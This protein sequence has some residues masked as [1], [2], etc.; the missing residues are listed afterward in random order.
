MRRAVLSRVTAIAITAWLVAIFGTSSAQEWVKLREEGANF[1]DIQR[2]FNQYWE[3]REVQKGKGWKPFKRWEYWTAPRVYPSGI[4]PEPDMNTRAFQQY[5]QRRGALMKGAATPASVATAIPA[6]NWTS[7]GPNSWTRANGSNVAPGLGRVSAIA[8]HPTNSSII[9]LGTPAGGLWK[10]TDAGATWSTN[11]ENLTVLGISAIVI[12]P[13]NTNVMYIATGDYD[14]Q[15]TYSIGVLKSTDGGATWNTTG[16]NWTVT[17]SRTISKLLIHP[18]FPDTLYAATSSGIYRTGNAGTTWSQRISSNWKDIEFKPGVPTTVYGVTNTQFWKTTNRG[19]NW[20]QTTTGVPAGTN[21]F[22]IGVSSNNANYVYLFASRSDNSGFMGMY[23]STDSGVSFATQS[24]TPNILGYDFGVITPP[25]PPPQTGADEGGQGNYDLAFAVSPTDA[26]KIYTGGINIWKSTDGGVNWTR[27]THW[28]YNATFPAADPAYVHADVHHLEFNGSTLFTGTDGGFFKSTDGGT[29]WA[30]LSAGMNSTQFYRIGS[31]AGSANLVYGGA[32]DNTNSRYTGTTQWESFLSGD[33][34]ECIVDPTNSNIVYTCTQKGSL[35][36]STDAGANFSSIKSNITEDGAWVTPYVMDPVTNT[37]LYA[38]YVNVWRTLNSGT[39]WTN[40]TNGTVGTDITDTFV[41]LAVA[42]SNSNYIYGVKRTKVYKTTDGGGAWTDITAGL[43]T[44][45]YTR[46]AVASN[47]PQKIWITLS[48]YLSGNKVYASTDGGAT[49]ANYSGT[50]PNLPFNTIVHHNNGGNDALYAGADI[51]VYYRDNTMSDWELYQ[52]GLPNAPVRE[53]E[54]HPNSGNLRAATYGRGLWQTPLVPAGA[55]GAALAFDGVND[56]VNTP[57]RTI[58]TADFTL[59]VWVYPRSPSIGGLILAQDVSGVHENQFRLG[60]HHLDGS[61]FYF[62]M[63]DQTDTQTLDLNGFQDYALTGT[64]S[65]NQWNHVAV[66]RQGASHNLYID[67]VLT[68]S[69]TTSRVIDHNSTEPFRLGARGNTTAQDPFNGILDEVRF[70]NQ[71]LSAAEILARMNCELTGTESSLADYY[72]FNHGEADGNNA[73]VTTLT[74][75]AGGNNNGTLNNFTLNGAGSNWTAPGGVT[76]GTS[77]PPPGAALAFDG[78]NDYVSSSVLSTATTNVTLEAWVN[79]AGLTGDDQIVFYNGSSGASGYGFYL[80]LTGGTF[81]GLLGGV[82]ASVSGVS[83]TVG[84]WTHLAMV[85]S[86]TSWDLYKD[87]VLIHSFSGTPNTPTTGFGIGASF[88]IPSDHFNGTIDEVRFWNVARSAAE[89][90]T[91]MNCELTGTEANLVAYYKFN[92]GIAGGNN[93]GVTMLTDIAGGDNNGT[94]NNFALTG[95]TSNWVSPGGVTSWTSCTMAALAA[96]AGNDNPHSG[97]ATK[98]N[99][100]ASGGNG[101]YTYAWAV[102][103]GPNAGNE[104]FSNASSPATIFKPAAKGN[105]VLRFTV[106]DGMT[107]SAADNVAVT[108]NALSTASISGDDPVLPGTTHTYT[109]TTDAMSPSYLWIVTN[110][111][112]AGDNEQSSVEVEAGGS[113]LPMLVEVFV[114]DGVTSDVVYA[115]KSVTV[116]YPFALTANAGADRTVPAGASTTL[117][118]SPAATGGID[119]LTYEWSPT[120]GL[121]NPNAANPIAQLATTTTYTL[122]ITDGYSVIA[123]DQVTV[124]VVPNLALNQPATASSSKPAHPPGNAV[125]DNTGTHW[126]SDVVGGTTKVW[127]RVD[128]GALYTIDNVVIDWSG[129]FYAK[130]Y[131]IQLSYTAAAGTWETVYTDNAGNG[132]IDNVTFPPTVGR[133]VRIMMTKHNETVER[134]NEVYVAA[135]A[136]VAKESEGASNQLSVTSYQL[137]QNYPNPFNPETEIAFAL[138]EAGHV[139]VAIYSITGQVVKQLAGGN[140]AGGWHQLLWDG[141]NESGAGV[142]A[143]LYFYRL[144]AR[145]ETGEVKFAQ[146]RKMAFVK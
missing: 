5:L 80:S 12:D 113:H 59:E 61:I 104:Q 144:T 3:G 100:S 11:T 58:G 71:A 109:V 63:S 115:F 54:V 79:W 139:T 37:T 142:A 146:T 2:S 8:F 33:G 70:W 36:R 67:G 143:G 26:N 112:V 48:G 128:L 7:L 82:T 6:A 49:W 97:G 131:Q 124:T 50:L 119:P 68:D 145:G 27:K 140:F 19:D 76:S 138:P 74:D 102:E 94:L 42:P 18:T 64:L 75:I 35:K 17:Q 117:G 60:F 56:F 52:T 44:A 16:L 73:G 110:G 111:T 21:R 107:A 69:Y 90:L 47:D 40:L 101:G 136:P 81:T 108:V 23:R 105:Y 84:T 10:S 92:Q 77:C 88:Q 96:N 14:S 129:S 41:D 22:N 29:N 24:T 133:Y 86:G 135:D 43:P 32:Q 4:L 120:T 65:L 57:S 116:T 38:G 85:G 121:N 25:F 99:G 98:L 53:L 62:M 83:P 125:D 34:A 66:T 78:V 72:N 55:P 45:S 134:I 39:S 15:D 1:Y 122:T 127:W 20:T 28:K 89:I 9:F 130:Q 51:G 126:R 141:R 118:G 137:A 91:K 93:A 106:H 13:T 46:I 123:T 114:T 103:S 87:G 30:D 95:M 132:G 31:F